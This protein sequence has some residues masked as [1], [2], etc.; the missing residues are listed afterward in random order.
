MAGLISI[1]LA[2]TL[3]ADAFA[4]PPPAPVPPR[5]HLE[6]GEAY[7][8][9]ATLDVAAGRM[10]AVETIRLTNRAALPI[11]Y[12]NLTVQP[13][14]FGFYQPTGEVTVDGVAAGT[15][16]TTGTNLRVD[17]PSP[18]APRSSAT[19]R[20]P[21]RLSVGSAGG[22]FTA[23]LSRDRG[24]LS[25][26]Q[27][28]PMVSP[29]HDI[30]AV[31]DPR[32]TRSADR[33]RLE[34]TTTA[35]QPRNAVACPGLLEAPATSGSRWVC[36]IENARDFGFV[37]N[38]R[39]RLTERTVGETRMRV[40]T[41]S[42]DGGR[43]ADLAEHALRRLNELY[44]PYPWP[45][46]VLAEVGADGGFSMEYPAAI[47][48]TRGKVVDTYVLYHEVAHQWFYA[49]LGND[50]MREPWLDEAFAD[51]TARYLMGTGSRDQCSTR[52]VDSSVFDWPAGLTTG[53]DWLS[54]DGYFHAVFYKGSEF[55]NAVR[56]AMGDAEFFGALREHIADNQFGITTARR[57]LADLQARTDADLQPIY[58]R[59]LAAY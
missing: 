52:P 40:Y 2:V 9:V 18:L 50:Q 1:L 19:L 37:V 29:E 3:S 48:L 22:A 42:V 25:F 15:A 14:A 31:G 6:A 45:E 54:C 4:P 41:E 24:V 39:F 55:L 32:I 51:F 34:L 27:W 56:V 30:Y 43:T 49:Q 26:G 59:Y 10:D 58:A 46:L 11:T 13:R 57:L 17:L 53:G 20:L 21:F 23:R 47:H 33:I 36:E 5:T 44:G 12:V 8:V 35:P 16:W 7:E 38:P 28:L